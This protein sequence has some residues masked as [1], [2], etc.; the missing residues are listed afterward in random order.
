MTTPVEKR[1]GEESQWR[2][3]GQEG[4][5]SD[6]TGGRS[7]TPGEQVRAEVRR[8]IKGHKAKLTVNRLTV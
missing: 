1:H 3:E 5:Q 4:A 6:I 2:D 8:R 7:T